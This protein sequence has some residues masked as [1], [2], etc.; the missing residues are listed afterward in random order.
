MSLRW[1]KMW[2]I[3]ATVMA[4]STGNGG[5]SDA[6]ASGDGDLLDADDVV[7]A[8]IEPCPEEMILIDDDEGTAFCM[9][10][11]E[12]PGIEGQAPTVGV[13]WFQARERCVEEAKQLCLEE[14]WARACVGTPTG[15]C[16]GQ[17]GVS[18]RRP[19]C[20]SDLGVLDMAGNVGEWTASPGGSVTFW[21]RGGS[22][23]GG[24]VGCDIREEVDAEI[25]RVDVGLRCCKQ[26][27]RQ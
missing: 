3:I 17:I 1:T 11:F 13:A 25:H 10:R 18:G 26:P 15:A 27:R 22:G 21:V 8:P 12:H 23:E 6:D 7:D 14:Q 19:E 5:P 4:C 9:D 2:P 16:S 24:S 20:I